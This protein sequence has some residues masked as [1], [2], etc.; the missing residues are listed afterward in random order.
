MIVDGKWFKNAI[1]LLQMNWLRYKLWKSASSEQLATIN[2]FAFQDICYE[3]TVKNRTEHSTYIHLWPLKYSTTVQVNMCDVCCNEIL[4]TCA[5]LG[6]Q[7][8]S[9]RQFHIIPSINHK[10]LPWYVSMCASMSWWWRSVCISEN[11]INHLIT[12]TI[13]VRMCH[14]THI[15]M[16]NVFN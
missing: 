4:S 3:T 6:S 11:Y 1:Q 10:W 12:L 7:S 5:I 9:T 15:F 14:Y 8:G 13:G 16:N 2:N